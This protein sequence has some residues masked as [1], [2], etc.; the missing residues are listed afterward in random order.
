MAD[1][2]DHGLHGTAGPGHHTE[3]P[4]TCHAGIQQVAVAQ[5]GRHVGQRQDNGRKLRPLAFVNG[6]R[7][8]RLN[9]GK[10]VRAVG[11]AA[12]V[13]LHNDAAGFG[14]HLG[15]DAK[16][17]VVCADAGFA[18]APFIRD[19]I[20]IFDLHDFIA[21]AQHPAALFPGDLGFVGRGRVEYG[22][23]FPVQL[24]TAGRADFGRAKHLDIRT[25]SRP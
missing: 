13:H 20:I 15:N 16:I 4:R 18:P 11:I 3:P 8:G 6:H 5:P 9:L 2:G 19:V 10:L 25:G 12:V 7:I 23:Q 24:H 17:P 14:V 22:L 1:V 21:K